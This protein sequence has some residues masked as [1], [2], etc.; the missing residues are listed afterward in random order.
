MKHPVK[1]CTTGNDAFHF[2]SRFGVKLNPAT[3]HTSYFPCDAIAV[4]AADSAVCVSKDGDVFSLK[5][6]SSFKDDKTTV[7]YNTQT[8]RFTH[9]D[10][11]PAVLI[12]AIL[13]NT[14][15]RDYFTCSAHPKNSVN[16]NVAHEFDNIPD[17]SCEVNETQDDQ[18]TSSN[19]LNT[20]DDQATS[21]NTLNMQ[22]DQATSSNMQD[23]QDDQATSS[24]TLNTQDTPQDDQATSKPVGKTVKKSKKVKSRENNVA[25]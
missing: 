24:N 4:K 23:T 6:S 8:N 12:P 25:E 21:S 2:D 18:A 22:D 10:Y 15:F 20:Q 16:Y 9:F 3:L 11:S 13:A 17:G 14:K 5:V 7:R 19:T 1:Y